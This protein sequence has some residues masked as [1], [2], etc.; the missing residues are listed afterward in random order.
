MIE[1]SSLSLIQICAL[2]KRP[3][4]R[5][6]TGKSQ[7]PADALKTIYW[8][9]E[10]AAWYRASSPYSLGKKLEPAGYVVSGERGSRTHMHRNKWSRYARGE[11]VP[12]A[13]LLHRIDRFSD[14]ITHPLWDLLDRPPS[15]SL[16]LTNSMRRFTPEV[17]IK[18]GKIRE[19]LYL[20]LNV[21][22]SV[23]VEHTSELS[24]IDA[25]GALVYLLREANILDKF[26]KFE[27]VKSIYLVMLT[28]GADF[29]ERG[30]LRS[31]FE[32]IQRNLIHRTYESGS[33][34]SYSSAHYVRALKVFNVVRNEFVVHHHGVCR[35][36]HVEHFNKYF[37]AGDFGESIQK[38]A[39]PIQLQMNVE[40]SKDYAIQLI[41]ER[42]K[43]YIAALLSASRGEMGG[44]FSPEV[45]AK[46]SCACK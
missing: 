25:L 35:Q 46:I 2:A 12:Q 17:Q 36:A 38:L 19:V 16:G 13:N 10:L 34:L 24:P 37:Y 11:C 44:M 3:R 9:H 14:V 21:G 6:P 23:R 18:I 31:L 4:F 26:P 40:W 28:R 39:Y 15:N 5:R 27:I 30:V 33:V 45:R 22:V 1:T 43:S 7:G 8:F 32:L 41:R 29:Y 42:R 20:P